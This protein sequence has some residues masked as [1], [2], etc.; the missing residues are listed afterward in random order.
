V[1]L[2][3][4]A[5]DGN[6]RTALFWSGICFGLAFLMKQPG[7][8]FAVFA[9]GYVAWVL[10]RERH[11]PVGAVVRQTAMLAGA[12]AI[13]FLVVCVVLAAS[14][15]FGTFWFWTFS[16]ASQYA[17]RVPFGDGWQLLT[18]AMGSIAAPAAGL[19]TLAIVGLTA[20]FWDQKARTA[21]A[22]LVGFFVFSFFAVCPGL[23]FR[24]HYFV[25]WLPSVAL[26][27]GVA[28]S[29]LHGLLVGSRAPGSLA[30]LPLV[31]F[32]AS[33]GYSLA[34]HSEFFFEMSPDAACRAMYKNN[35]F[36]ESIEI[37]RYIR[38]RSGA[39]D[40]VAVIGSE[41]QIPFYAGRRSA[42]GYVYTYALVENHPYAHQMQLEMI[43]QIERAHPR[44]LVHVN[45]PT[46]WL[47]PR[48]ADMTLLK[49]SRQYARE[50]Y[51]QVGLAERTPDGD[52]AYYWGREAAGRRP[53]SSSSVVLLEANNSARPTESPR[54][55]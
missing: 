4:N 16:Y 13:P 22:F 25:V 26:L 38:E 42:T 55:K 9:V 31:L 8:L 1:L 53:Q 32:A 47:L 33:W 18:E 21:R 12:A 50:R 43:E 40:T 20:I 35:P 46:S 7:G 14:G 48:D 17:S 34:R 52:T 36:P 28:V 27:A 15:V 29:A 37:A 49:W 44:F 39:D 24:E 23:Y 41:P 5:L 3:L 6:R 19:F 10:R 11:Q 51:E 30:A 54:G 45:T 2:L